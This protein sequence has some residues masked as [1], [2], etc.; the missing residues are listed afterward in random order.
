MYLITHGSQFDVIVTTNLFGDILSDEAAGLVGGL[1]LAPSLNQGDDHA[2]A[3]AVHGS[4]PDIVHLHIANPVAEILSG[5]LLLN[6]LAERH[7]L[8]ALRETAGDIEHAVARALAEGTA[9]TPDLGGTANTEEL[10][11]AIMTYL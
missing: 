11:Q 3:Q 10:A 7:A 4:A 2:M 5:T 8:P 6:W 1:G 9:I